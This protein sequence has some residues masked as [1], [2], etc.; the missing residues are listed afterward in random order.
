MKRLIPIGVVALAI[1]SFLW[2]RFW[3]GLPGTPTRSDY[4]AYAYTNITLVTLFVVVIAALAAFQQ[5]QYISEQVAASERSLRFQIYRDLLNMIDEFRT[6]RHR[7]QEDFPEDTTSFDFDS[8]SQDQLE[9]LERVCRPFDTL[10]MLVAQ[11]VVPLNFVL[12]FHTRG[13]VVVWHRLAPYINLLRQKRNQST[14]M[15]QFQMLAIEAKQ[16]RDQFFP[17]EETFIVTEEDEEL[18]KRWRSECQ[19]RWWIEREFQLRLKK[20]KNPHEEK[21]NANF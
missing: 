20:R 13:I 18:W 14:L 12:D 10:G 5:L 16:H 17:H 8:L 21:T 11:G 4:F 6:D 9:Q 3:L 2:W 7:I 19:G 15:R 1:L